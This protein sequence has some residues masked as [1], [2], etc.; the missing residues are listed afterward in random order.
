M[1]GKTKRQLIL[2]AVTVLI[3]VILLKNIDLQKSYQIIK[4]VD[5]RYL[6]LAT[7]LSLFFPVLSAIRWHFIVL[8]LGANL[9][10]WPSYKI[11]MAAWPLSTVTPAKSGDLIKVVYLRNVLAYSE[12][13]GVILAERVVDVFCLACLAVIG[14]L[15]VNLELAQ[16]FGA[17]ILLCSV[18]G[19]IFVSTPWISLLPNKFQTLFV[20][21]F[22]AFKELYSH[23]PTLFLVLLVTLLNWFLSILQTWL[24]YQA[25]QISVPLM[26]VFAAL[27]VA[28]FVGLLPITIAG[29]GTRD[30]ALIQLF[31]QYASNEGSL[32]VGILYSFFG[33]WFLTLLGLP[34]MK[35]AF[36][37]T[38]VGVDAKRL[39][40]TV[41]EE[42]Q[43]SD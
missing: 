36:E 17:A 43:P 41:Y 35:S 30:T 42:N 18:L 19:M 24:C 9:G 14:G 21:L 13:T 15:L 22:K 8:R 23:L 29:M 31:S 12:T 25:F 34:F 37:G 3:F 4:Q 11:I 32:F 33:Y 40:E 16:W 39:K 28:I 26:Y 27:P 2:I 38:I 20:N 5:W 10:V 7:L 1:T 6:A